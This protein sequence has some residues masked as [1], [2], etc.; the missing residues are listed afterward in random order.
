[1]NSQ[2]IM[3]RTIKALISGCE[4][5][6]LLD[7]ERDFFRR[8]NPWGLILFHRNCSSSDQLKLLT[9]EFREAVGRKDAPVLIDQEGGRVQRMSPKANPEW[10]SYPSASRYGMLYKRCPIH[11]LRTARH[12]GRLMAD[13]LAAVGITVNC[14]P[15]LDVPQP[16]SHAVISDRAY[17]ISPEIVIALSRAHVAGFLDAG[18]LPV[19]KHIPGHGRATVDSHKELPRVSATR[20]EL[21]GLDFKTFAG[22]ADCPMAMTAHVVFEVLDKNNP[23]TQSK[24]VIRDVIRRQLGFNGLLMTDDLSMKALGGSFAEK[25]SKSLEA[26]CDVVLHCNGVMAEMEEVAEA[27]GA[28]S[29]RSLARAKS[30]LKM[31]RKPQRYDQKMALKDLEAVMAIEVA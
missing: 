7:R 13:D 29:G 25:A 30:A 6:R 9:A 1:L 17:D 11:A 21:E 31:R 23:V 5:P 2:T 12:V 22:F 20:G 4:G 14:L 26:G 15:V 27:T 10:R 8:A 18:V 16:G 24:R 3:K 28:L 19:M